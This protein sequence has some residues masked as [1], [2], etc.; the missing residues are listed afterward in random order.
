MEII[1]TFVK[2]DTLT[3]HVYGTYDEPLFLSKQVGEILGLTN[4]RMSLKS[5]TDKW[6]V[7]KP[8]D[9]PGGVQKMTFLKEMG[10]YKLCMRSDKAEAEVFQDWICEEVLPSIRKTGYYQM[11]NRTHRKSNIFHITDEKS[12]HIKVIEFVKHQYPEALISTGLGE[13][14]DTPTKRIE[15]YQK[16]YLSGEP[17]LKINNLHMQYNGLIIEF[18]TPTGKGDISDKQLNLIESYKLNGYDTLI[19]ND[20]DEILLK[21]I[22]YMMAIRVK[23]PHCVGK[24]KTINTLTNHKRF[25]HRICN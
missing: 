6:K 4:I 19:S 3:L 10:L 2:S 15:A 5:I 21:I 16:G 20:Y 8:F 25:F 1:K 12:L 23:C 14:Q 24:F 13:L 22:K 7:V 9:T 11:V 17:D 18:K